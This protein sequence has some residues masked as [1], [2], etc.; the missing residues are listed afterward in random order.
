MPKFQVRI[1]ELA[2]YVVDVECDDATAAAESAAIEKFT[3]APNVNRYF[4]HSDDRK[5]DVV[6]EVDDAGLPV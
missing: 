3:Q 6:V 2:Y 5:V 1:E 4:S